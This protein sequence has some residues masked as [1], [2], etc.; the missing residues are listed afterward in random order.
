M[1]SLCASSSLQVEDYSIRKSR[2]DIL[3]FCPYF[4]G[5]QSL[6]GES[7]L[8][9][10]LAQ[11]ALLLQRNSTNNRKMLKSSCTFL[12][13]FPFSFF[14]CSGL[15]EEL[16][17]TT[18][19]KFDFVILLV[20]A[21]SRQSFATF[22]KILQRLDVSFNSSRSVIVVTNGETIFIFVL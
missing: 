9:R 13:N 17:L 1:I 12:Q 3:V 18:P 6:E 14:A 22:K 5:W 4:L 7:F 19:R 2:L 15:A 11:T 20:D 8:T 16:P 21:L 10:S